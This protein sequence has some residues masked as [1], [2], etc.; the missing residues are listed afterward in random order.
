MKILD[1]FKKK[2]EE[3]KLLDLFEFLKMDLNKFDELFEDLPRNILIH[4]YASRHVDHDYFLDCHGLMAEFAVMNLLNNNDKIDNKHKLNLFFAGDLHANFDDFVC[5]I[6]RENFAKFL[7]NKDFEINFIGQKDLGEDPLS[8]ETRGELEFLVNYLE[9]AKKS[10]DFE[11]RSIGNRALSICDLAHLSRIQ[12]ICKYSNFKNVQPISY[13][14]ILIY[15]YDWD[16]KNLDDFFKDYADFF[17]GMSVFWKAEK[18]KI[19]LT[20]D[21]KFL[22]FISRVLGAKKQKLLELT[23]KF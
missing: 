14:A 11:I 13:Q 8:C 10:R 15:F 21:G 18:I 4:T 5:K 20:R 6:Y 22:A 9:K 1:E 19:K 2:F 16:H 17:Q 12:K 3:Q 7:Q 23:Q